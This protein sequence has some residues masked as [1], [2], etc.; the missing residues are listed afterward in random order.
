MKDI[1]YIYD[2]DLVVVTCG[3][4]E[5]YRGQ[6]DY[7]DRDFQDA[8]WKQVGRHYEVTIG[9]DTYKLKILT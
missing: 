5:I 1:R 9:K 2:D 3:K 6:W 8:N 4:N 7:L